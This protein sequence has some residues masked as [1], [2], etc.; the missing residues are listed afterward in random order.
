HT[1]VLVARRRLGAA[2]LLN[3]APDQIVLPIQGV[4]HDRGLLAHDAL[5]ATIALREPTTE[6]V[7][8]RIGVHADF[9]RV[10]ADVGARVKAGRPA[11]EVV[12]LQADEQV[13]A[14]FRGFRDAVETD[15]AMYT[16]TSQ[17]GSERFL[18]AHGEAA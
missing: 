18:F 7:D 3:G 10:R 1:F 16:D 5:G 9:H 6:V 17:V 15:T 4:S 8:S 2:V 12:A 11:R 14:D 13:W